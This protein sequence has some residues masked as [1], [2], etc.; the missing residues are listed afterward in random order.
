MHKS[1]LAPSSCT[2]GPIWTQVAGWMVRV[3]TACMVTVFV[4]PS[5][6]SVPRRRSSG[7][8]RP[9][10]P[11]A[12]VCSCGD[13][14]LGKVN[15]YVPPGSFQPATAER[16]LPAGAADHDITTA[17]HSLRGPRSRPVLSQPPKSPASRQLCPASISPVSSRAHS[18]FGLPRTN[19]ACSHG[20]PR[21]LRVVN[22]CDGP[23]A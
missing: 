4:G 11:G 14:Y 1:D 21:S 23:S 2:S 12:A 22:W 18:P 6:C 8:S 19:S 7:S 15:R 16:N 13:G 3:S 20:H 9:R 17:N 5:I 10:A